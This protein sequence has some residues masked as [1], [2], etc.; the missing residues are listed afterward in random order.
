MINPERFRKIRRLLEL[1]QPDLTLVMDNVNKPHNLAAIIRTCDAVGIEHIHA[2]STRDSIRKK[3]KTAGGSTK[4]TTLHLHCSMDDLLVELRNEGMQLIVA[5]YNERSKDFRSV[6]FT[7]P[8]ALIMG[9][10]KF[11][12]SASSLNMSDHSIHIPMQGMVESLNVSVAAA[13][14]LFEA[15]RQ[16][17]EKGCYDTPSLPPEEFRERLFELCYPEISQKLSNQKKTYPELDENGHFANRTI[18][19]Q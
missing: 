19:E 13:V 17:I 5:D 12:P 11:G 9:A 2:I 6:D 4:W 8:T 14:I 10:E 15:Q 3:Q 16:R 18:Q 7:Q 1:R